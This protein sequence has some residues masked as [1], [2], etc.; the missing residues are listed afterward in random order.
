MTSISVLSQWMELRWKQLLTKLIWSVVLLWAF[1]GLV[2]LAL[3]ILEKPAP[4]SLQPYHWLLVIFLIAIDAGVKR[5][6]SS[7]DS[8]DYQLFSRFSNHIFP[9]II[10]AGI[11]LIVWE[12]V[13]LN[14]NEEVQFITAFG[15][16]LKWGIAIFIITVYVVVDMGT[17]LL[18]KWRDSLAESERFQK[19]NIQTRLDTLKSQI[20][21][22][23][24][25][26]SLNTLSGLIHEDQD[27]ASHFLRKISGVY[28]HIL[29][30]RDKDLISLEDE[31]AIANDYIQLINVR[32]E[33]TI[34]ITVEIEE[35]A[36][37]KKVVPLCLQM[38]MENAIKHNRASM[39]EPL[40]IS[41][42][43]QGDSWLLVSNNRQIR[44]SLEPSTKVGLRNIKARFGFITNREVEIIDDDAKFEVRLPLISMP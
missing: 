40:K 33:G 35:S 30:A 20:N 6:L 26:N 27:K 37:Q 31:M 11:L 42:A 14:W 15:Y 43:T 38:L 1:G 2:S 3:L 17:E 13:D 4:I 18:K 22:H 21:P 41:I 28:R 8:D 16:R 19:E 39:D 12:W 36:K 32:F 44:Q 24:L 34:V 5:Q 25:F 10:A 7:V 29:E 23:F 9:T